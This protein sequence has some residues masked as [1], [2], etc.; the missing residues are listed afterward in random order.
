V[1][2]VVA[3]PSIGAI[4]D[5]DHV[6]IVRIIDRRLDIV[7]IRRFIVINVNGFCAA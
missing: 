3:S 4:E 7:E 1:D 2:Q 5:D 6:A